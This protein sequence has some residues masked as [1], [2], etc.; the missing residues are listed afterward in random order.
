MRKLVLVL[1]LLAGAQTAHAQWAVV[2][3]ANVTQTTITAVKT[4]E[5]LKNQV[6]QMRRD[7]ENTIKQ[8]RTLADLGWNRAELRD[9]LNF[10]RGLKSKV[11]SMLKNY[12]D[13]D[14]TFARHGGETFKDRRKQWDERTEESIRASLMANGIVSKEENKNRTVDQLLNK[15]DTAENMLQAAQAIGNLLQVQSSQLDTLT[16]IVAA[17]AQAKQ[18]KLAKSHSVKQDKESHE[19]NMARNWGERKTGVPWKKLPNFSDR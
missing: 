4:A 18:L 13:I 7:L 14:R 8:A 16:T 3:A 5:Q 12:E 6:E 2:D 10:V 15:L 19:A 1:G 11:N 17:D 9:Y